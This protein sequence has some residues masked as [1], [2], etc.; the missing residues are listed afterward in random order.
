M[1]TAKHLSLYLSG[2]K[3]IQVRFQ[4]F[5]GVVAICLSLVAAITTFAQESTE[6]YQ[7]EM[8]A[9]CDANVSKGL[10]AVFAAVVSSDNTPII[11]SA[12]VRKFG[13][14]TAVTSDDKIHI[15][16]CTKAMTSVLIARLV[17]LGKL[18]WDQSIAES[19]PDLVEKIHADYHDVSLV[20]LLGHQGHIAANASNWHAH[21]RLPIVERRERIMLDNLAK[22][23]GPEAA[24]DFHYSNLGYMIA[25]HMAEVATGQPWEDLIREFI[26]QPLE[27]ATAGFGPPSLKGDLTQPWGHSLFNGAEWQS[28]QLDN[29][30]ALG[31]AGTVHL[32]IADWAK[33][34]RLFFKDSKQTLLTKESIA[35]LLKPGANNYAL[36]WGVV[37]RPWAK[38][39]ALSHSGSNTMWTA[40]VWIAPATNHAYI[41][42]TNSS[43]DDSTQVLDKLVG[44][45]IELSGKYNK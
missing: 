29:S 9:A 45:V 7:S 3:A 25:G 44:K 33:F 14:P 30:E 8:Q 4:Y 36:G 19:F 38:G 16:S 11:L 2:L 42:A 31:P 10:P 39:T 28:S 1:E 17:E 5:H 43:K 24:A 13:D 15:G 27:I 18:D 6:T 32:S 22:P 37:N 40:T 26:F 21:R 20:Q 12:G 35:R 34:H 41:V 23:R